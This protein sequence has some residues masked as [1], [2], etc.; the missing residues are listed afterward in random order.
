MKLACVQCSK[1]LAADAA[2]CAACGRPTDAD[3]DG[4]PDALDKLIEAKAKGILAAE[5]QAEAD[6]HAKKALADEILKL[7]R[8]DLTLSDQLKRNEAIPRNWARLFVDTVMTTFVIAAFAWATV[9]WLAH[10]VVFPLVSYSPAGW[11]ACPMQCDTCQGPGRTFA[12]NF[13]GS[14]KSAKGQMG[15]A[16]VCHNPSYDADKL[17][18]T[19]VRSTKNAVLQPYMVSSI[20]S[21][22][23]EGVMICSSTALY[24]G[25]ARTGKRRRR[26]DEK[27]AALER[28]RA[29]GRARLANLR[30]GPRPDPAGPFR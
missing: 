11:V 19:E 23:V 24:W 21:Y 27:R 9:G 28:A 2:F 30:G 20:V 4:V 15:Y 14:W 3:K 22:G 10:L 5:R 13:K 1:P 6:E 29:E 18:W 25:I 16:L 26:L 12:W 7:E 8:S 17:E